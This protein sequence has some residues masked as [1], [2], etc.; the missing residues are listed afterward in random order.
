MPISINRRL[1]ATIPFAAAALLLAGCTAPDAG[2]S[3]AENDAAAIKFVS[4]LNSAGQTAK[5]LDGGYVGL[6][7]PESEGG[8]A[9]GMSMTTQSGSA[10]GD[11]EPTMV[12]M[13][14]DE[15]GQWL[16]SST[17]SG[18]PEEGGMREAWLGCEEKVP[19][20]EQPVPEMPDDIEMID[21]E[22]VMAAGL[23]F[24]ACARENGY[25]DFADP[26]SD[27][28]LELPF[29]ITEDGLRSLMDACYDEDSKIGP[30]F[31]MESVEAAD[32]DVWA[33]LSDY[34]GGMIATPAMPVGP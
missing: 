11:D 12:I 17:A 24:A 18:Y 23:E 34:M 31:T 19:A 15:E 20:F 4:C 8:N 13:S 28:M 1:L 26:D 3:S 22:D 2:P 10:S 9:G 30:M 27:G 7:M 25:S 16:A 6:L 14:E 32:F 33:V 21:Q 5:I 29:G